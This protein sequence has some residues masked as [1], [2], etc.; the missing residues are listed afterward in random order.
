LTTLQA[1]ASAI[2]AAARAYLNAK[3]SIEGSV[4]FNPEWLHLIAGPLIFVAAAVVLRKP[5]SSWWPWL[6]VLAAELVNEAIDLALGTSASGE[7]RMSTTDLVVTMLL[8]TVLM[9]MA[10]AWETRSENT[11]APGLHL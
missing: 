1:I 4:P 5:L 8:P 2:E 9:A 3:G 10:R 11:E 7:L 6:V